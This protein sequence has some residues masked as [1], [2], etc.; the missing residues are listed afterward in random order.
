MFT[1]S[2]LR[3]LT[4]ES[5]GRFLGREC[6]DFVSHLPI[7][8]RRWSSFRFAP[9][10]GEADSLISA[11]GLSSSKLTKHRRLLSSPPPACLFSFFWRFLRLRRAACRSTFKMRSAVSLSS[12]LSDSTLGIMLSFVSFIILSLFRRRRSFFARSLLLTSSRLR[13]S[14]AGPRELLCSG[15]DLFRVLQGLFSSE[16]LKSWNSF[17]SFIFSFRFKARTSF[18]RSEIYSSNASF[19]ST[20]P[21]AS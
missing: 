6:G 11:L 2:L 19:R 14:R 7:D 1:L 17:L 8:P 20:Y 3:C 4:C 21:R 5:F 12:V 10:T 16:D 13:R 9:R 15:L 18:C